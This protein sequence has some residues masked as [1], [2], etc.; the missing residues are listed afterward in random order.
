MINMTKEQEK[1]LRSHVAYLFKMYQENRAK[2][3][4]YFRLL[5]EGVNVQLNKL[6]YERFTHEEE[7]YYFRFLEAEDIAYRVLG[8]DPPRPKSK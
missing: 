5:G 4:K 3:E 8:L 1:K 6:A 7:E 2:R